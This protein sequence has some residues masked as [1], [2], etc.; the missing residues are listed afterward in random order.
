M[1]R[2]IRSNDRKIREANILL[3]SS[4]ACGNKANANFRK[5]KLLKKAQEKKTTN[6][7]N[8]LFIE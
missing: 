7:F 1:N 3:L 2:K 8:I 6:D 4:I 5:L